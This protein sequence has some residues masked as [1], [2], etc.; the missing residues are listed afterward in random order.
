VTVKKEFEEFIAQGKN[1]FAKHVSS[2]DAEIRP[3]QEVIVVNEE[4]EVLGVGRAVLT[5]DEML[6]FQIGVAVKV[7]RGKDRHR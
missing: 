2:A 6:A 7:R 3:G 4:K 1:L 5:M